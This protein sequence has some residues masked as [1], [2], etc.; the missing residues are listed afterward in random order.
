[1]EHFQLVM[2]VNFFSV[3]QTVKACLP[4]LKKRSMQEKA[5]KGRTKTPPRVVNVTSFAGLVPGQPTMA[6]YGASK[7]AAESFC[8]ALRAELECWGI[9][10]S[11]INPSFHATKMVTGV[12]AAI[13]KSYR[14]MDQAKQEE[15]GEAF[16]TE[17]QRMI[18]LTQP[19]AW[20]PK[21]VL[22]VLRHATTALRPRRQ[23]LVG[24]DGRFFLVPLMSL[25]EQVFD[26]FS[27]FGSQ[28]WRLKPAAIR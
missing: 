12:E 10:V 25:P 2:D 14:E 28:R 17:I 1:M 8:R 7:H 16:L 21:N 9:D 15:Y 6:A 27:W 23:Y 5:G 22:R 3:V 26:W 24:M 13:T 4:L 19:Y 18:S 20:H 11:I